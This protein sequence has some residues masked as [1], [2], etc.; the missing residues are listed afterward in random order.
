M[1]CEYIFFNYILSNVQWRSLSWARVGHNPPG[2]I[3]KINDYRSFCE[4]LYNFVLILG[5]GLSKFLQSCVVTHPKNLNNS[6]I[7]IF[8]ET[9]KNFSKVI[10]F[11]GFNSSVYEFSGPPELFSGSATGNVGWMHGSV[12][13]S[14]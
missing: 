12:I 13:F 10:V 3:K 5:F 9:L 6:I 7:G 2:K 11:H 4:I 8:C 1:W 14:K